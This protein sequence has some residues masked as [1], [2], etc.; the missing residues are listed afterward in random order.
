MC[1]YITS[2]NSG[3]NGNC[4]YIG[5][6]REAILIDA[7]IS[8]RETEKRMKQLGLSM[9][10]VKAIFIS[11]EHGDHILG[12]PTLCKKYG[13]PLYTS[14]G[15]L[16]HIGFK[17]D[18]QWYRP[19]QAGEPVCI[20]DLRVVSFAKQH[21]AAEPHSFMVTADQTRVGIF[22]DIGEPCE[23]LIRHFGQCHAAFL[24][25]NYDD[26][27]LAEGKYPPHLKKRI[28]G[29]LG[30][31]S[32]N[33]ALALF[34]A[35]KPAYMSHLFLSHLSKE[36]NH[37]ELVLALFTPHAGNTRIIIA[38]RYE[39]TAVYTIQGKPGDAD[40]IPPQIQGSGIV[41]SKRKAVQTSLF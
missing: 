7:G 13:L 35:H 22:T 18:K 37:P 36:N 3:S 41:T 20:G 26:R 40:T 16:R 38:S 8:C 10:M 6:E 30:H 27:M 19:L 39:A 5:N 12:I 25:A 24:E 1:L 17:L 9:K 4:Y 15:T 2:L 28:S 31:L 23:D 11:H 34:K 21:D 32:N 29:T 33:Q 14:P